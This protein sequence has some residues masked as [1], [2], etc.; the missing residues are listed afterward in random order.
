MPRDFIRDIKLALFLDKMSAT[1]AND[2][3]WA[4]AIIGESGQPQSIKN[5]NRYVYAW[6][7]LRMRREYEAACSG[8]GAGEFR[9]DDRDENGNLTTLKEHRKGPLPSRPRGD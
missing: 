9:G 6:Q 4:L 7:H 5:A 3:E 8:V 1:L 2:L